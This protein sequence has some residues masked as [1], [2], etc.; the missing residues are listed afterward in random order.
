MPMVI[1][2]PVEVPAV[3]I[4]LM[5]MFAGFASIYFLF[6]AALEARRQDR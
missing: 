1:S 3:I 4:L 6:K 5:L 2:D